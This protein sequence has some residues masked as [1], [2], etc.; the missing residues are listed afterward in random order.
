MKTIAVFV[1]SLRKES[2]NR[3]LAQALEKLAEGKLKFNWVELADLPHYNDDLWENPPASV[4]TLKQQ[5]TDADGVL[6]VTPEYNR[7]F[8]SILKDAVDWATRPYGQNVWIGKPSA[9]IGTSLGQIGTAIG[10][11]HLR[12][13]LLV[14]GTIVMQ[15]PEAYIQWKPE[16]F[17]ADHQITNAETKKFL[18][19]YLDSFANW[20]ERHG[21]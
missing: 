3:K 8:S 6:F 16:S 17:S 10:Q 11:N 4:T 19:G 15:M 9:V 7:N 12:L 20:I 21:G 2:L 13:Q 5:V 14:A 18:E 1:G